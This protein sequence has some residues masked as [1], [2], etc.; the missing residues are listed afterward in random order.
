[1]VPVS[2]QAFHVP[3]GLWLMSSISRGGNKVSP[4]QVELVLLSHPAISEAIVTGVPDPIMGERIHA[5]IVPIDGA[6]PSVQELRNWA[7]ERL[8]K[9]KIPDVIH[10]GSEIPRGRTGKADRGQFR[11]NLLEASPAQTECKK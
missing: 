2:A 7:S 1:M 3:V 8:D 5:L 9:F 10:L 4:I 6:N 11:R